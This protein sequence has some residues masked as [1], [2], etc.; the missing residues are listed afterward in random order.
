MLRRNLLVSLGL[1]IF[2]LNGCVNPVLVN[3]TY[4][5]PVNFRSNKTGV[6]QLSTGVVEGA[7]GSTLMY[8]GPNIFVPVSSGPYPHLQ[9]NLKD[10]RIF[11][12]SLKDELNRLNLLRVTQVTEQRIEGADVSI[13]VVFVQTTHMPHMQ[14]YFLNVAMQLIAGQQS[15]AKRYEILSSEGDSI[16]TKLNTNAADGKE[17]AAKRLMTELIPDI[18]EFVSSI[19]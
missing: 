12:E 17:K 4:D 13:D 1:T 8:A 16:W 7:S 14:E 5:E 2:L 18:E 15:F 3:V 11:V 9:F 6:I 10:Q 19:E